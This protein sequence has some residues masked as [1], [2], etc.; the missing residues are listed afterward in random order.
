MIVISLILLLINFICALGIRFLVDSESNNPYLK[1][2]AVRIVLL[3]PPVSIVILMGSFLFAVLYTLWILF[4]SY[5][6]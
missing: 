2:K 6:D 5:L 1:S 4:K 3:I